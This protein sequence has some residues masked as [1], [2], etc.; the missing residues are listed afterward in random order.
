MINYISYLVLFL[1]F[2]TLCCFFGPYWAKGKRYIFIKKENKFSCIF[3]Y[4]IIF[5]GL[6]L[7]IRNNILAKK[8]TTELVL[9]F[10][11]NISKLVFHWPNMGQKSIKVLMLI[12]Y[13]KYLLV[14]CDI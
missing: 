3:G 5:N 1:Y 9:L 11:K 2:L 7:A 13:L 14:L 12:E 10:Y 6:Y 8:K 4:N